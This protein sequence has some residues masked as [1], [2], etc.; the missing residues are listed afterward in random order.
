MYLPYAYSNTVKQKKNEEILKW[1]LHRLEHPF[2]E[3]GTLQK[4]A[5]EKRI[6]KQSGNCKSIEKK[7]QKGGGNKLV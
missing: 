4:D 6:R 7:V 1:K 5:L 2:D 3:N